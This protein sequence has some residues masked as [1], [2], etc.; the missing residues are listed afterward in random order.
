MRGKAGA[1][2]G[3]ISAKDKDKVIHL[4]CTRNASHLGLQ[5]DDDSTPKSVESALMY[6]DAFQRLT[7]HNCEREALVSQIRVLGEA[8]GAHKPPPLNPEDAF[9]AGGQIA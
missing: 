6:C 8:L 1:M 3:I 2:F 5:G 7:R 9:A 4:Q